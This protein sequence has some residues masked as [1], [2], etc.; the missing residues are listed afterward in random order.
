MCVSYKMCLS[1]TTLVQ[2]SPNNCLQFIYA[3][4]SKPC[5]RCWKWDKNIICQLPHLQ[6]RH[7]YAFDYFNYFYSFLIIYQP[8]NFPMSN[9]KS[10][11]KNKFR[12]SHLRAISNVFKANQLVFSFFIFIHL[13]IT[14]LGIKRTNKNNCSFS[15]VSIPL[16]LCVYFLL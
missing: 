3:R 11:H 12:F 6:H 7:I 9:Q 16:I 10:S 13:S 4:L 8:T 2:S 14:C 5:C 15:F 1:T